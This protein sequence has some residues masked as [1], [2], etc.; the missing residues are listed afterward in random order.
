VRSERLPLSFAQQ[1]LWFLDQLEPESPFYNMPAAVRLSGRLDVGALEA[2]FSEIIRRHEILRTTFPS[3]SGEPVQVIAPAASPTLPVTDLSGLPEAERQTVTQRLMAEEAQ[4][5]FDL[6]RG[7]LWRVQLLRHSGEEHILLSTLHHIVADGWS[8]NLLVEEIAALYAAFCS[9]SA[10][11]LAPLPIQYAD[12]AA[13]QRRWLTDEVLDP[14][15]SY[16]RRQLAGAPPVLEL[17]ADH[18][19]PAVQGFRGASHGFTLPHELTQALKGLS[20]REGVTLFMTLLAG[21][22]ALLARLSG[23]ADVVVGTPVAG[24]TQLETERLIGL[25]V[26][27]LVLRA[28]LADNPSFEQLL[29]RV[30]GLTLEAYAHQDVPFERLVEDLQ[31]ERSL[32]HAPLFQVM[33]ALQHEAR[34]TLDLAGL[35]LEQLPVAQATTHFDLGLSLT[36]SATGLHGILEYNLEL[37]EPATVERLAAHYEAL[38]AAAA[39]EPGRGVWGLPLLRAEEQAQVEQWSTAP[40]LAAEHIRLAHELFEGHAAQSPEAVALV[41]GGAR[42]TYG[43]LNARANQLARYLRESGVTAQA[44]VG[45]LLDRTAE[46]VSALLALLKL[47]AVYVP[48]DPALPA[49]RLSF[50]LED[51][52]VSLLLTATEWQHLVADTTVPQLC[53]DE[54]ASALAAQP[55]EGLGPGPAPD[56]L[57]YLIYTSG[58]TGRPKAVAVGRRQLA[59][60]L[61]ASRERFQFLPGDRLPCVSG[62]GFDISLW[63]LLVPLTAGASVDLLTREQVVDVE[64][65]AEAVEEATLLHAV[66]ALMGQLVTH[67]Q[68][69]EQEATLPRLRQVFVGGDA[70]APRLLR[71]MA[72]V[73]PCAQLHV[74]YGPTEATIICSSHEVPAPPSTERQMLGRALPGVRLSIRDGA[75]QVTP[76]GV[77]GELWVGGAG[78]TRGYLNREELTAEKFVTEGGERWYRSGDRARWLPEGEVE[79]LGRADEQV[80]VRGYRIELGEVEAILSSHPAVS[81][82]VVVAREDRAG[83][84]RLV[85][86]VIARD[87]QTPA[88]SELRA[89]LQERLPD[90]MVPSAFV[91]LAELPLTSNGKVDKRA[92]PAPDAARPEL[93]DDFV[94]PRTPAEETLCSIWAEVLGVERV[95]VGDNFF[96]LGGDSILSIQ[97]VAR[98]AQAGL[99]LTPRQLFQ[100]QSVAAL[101][102]AVG[103]A[104]PGAAAEQG[105]VSGEVALTPVQARFFAQG[106]RRPEHFNQAVLLEM[107]AGVNP[108]WLEE[109]VRHLLAQHDALRMRFSEGAGGWRQQNL[110]EEAGEVFTASDL[111]GLARDEQRRALEEE[112][113]RAQRSLRLSEGP[114][115]RCVY[116]DLGAGGNGRL[117]LVA[118][119]LVVDGVSWRILLADLERA[120]GQL[121][122][123]REVALGAKTSSFRQWAEAL[124]VYA[125]SEGLA[126]QLPYWQAQAA[127][128]VPPLPLD[129]AAGEAAGLNTVGEAGQVEV[130]LGAEQTRTLLTEACGAYRAQAQEVLLAAFALGYAR[131][132]GAGRLRVE[133]EGHG[134]EPEVL[135]A[136]VGGAV[137][138]GGALD[139]TRTVGWFTALY[140]VLLEVGARAGAVEA[141][142]EV[143]GRLR[144][145][146]GAGVGYGA[147]RWMGADETARAALAGGAEISFNYLGQLDQVLTGSGLFAGVGAEGGGRERGADE[148]REYLLE[149]VASVVGGRLRVRVEYAAGVL[150]RWRVEAL[151]RELEAALVEII[152]GRAEAEAGGLTPSDFPEAEL[153]QEDLDQLVA[154]LS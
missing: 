7:P 139:L 101:A 140:P 91:S 39:A 31:V 28:D 4:R 89:H 6:A 85:A 40:P 2:A 13:W 135:A 54:V 42:L 125:R 21:F 68:G 1:R 145:V 35:R 114:L 81:Q 92:L 124:Q 87:G 142:K 152:G 49:E 88:V 129:C 66:P 126:A 52:G 153:S 22:Q 83:E 8:I 61:S 136:G 138:G 44:R 72:G 82:C 94:A 70:V 64:R 59:H 29:K 56:S 100:H 86:Y 123:G 149:V 67:L 127:A 150:G 128:E 3:V 147:L 84:K 78:V 18:A 98:A 33:F 62:L 110:A 25:F 17:P 37:F 146:P 20:R 73:F 122:A 48:L 116:F 63:E 32:A 141:V 118:H 133:V 148:R 90:Y 75:G 23:Q 77:A 69:R 50:M 43:E 117:L 144:A 71:Q 131:W 10:A 106:L 154:E 115:L 36:E 57:A 113:E 26:N 24:R 97:V 105:A 53:L 109:A 132:S 104:E 11:P 108:A 5:A 99:R 130:G 47:G 107:A 151:G 112:A 96:E 76:V 19:R 55:T 111:S 103:T 120:Y 58:S 137:A 93:G 38:L 65:L 45:V 30:R 46:A 16:W 74:L 80:K 51:A 60:T 79:F 34:P 119:H 143:K 121:A 12:Y 102:A 15:L 134:R 95:G 41:C 9:E 14:Q 27:T